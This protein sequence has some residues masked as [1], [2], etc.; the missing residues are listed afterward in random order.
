MTCIDIPVVITRTEY[1]RLLEL[2][3]SMEALTQRLQVAEARVAVEPK[4]YS[5]FE[6]GM[7][8]QGTTEQRVKIRTKDG[9]MCIS[10][11]A[12]PQSYDRIRTACTT[13]DS[14][15]VAMTNPFAMPAIEHRTYAFCG[16]CRKTGLR[17]FEEI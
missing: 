11:K 8:A 12:Y 5:D 17:M 4:R 7:G 2:K 13:N 15:I 14:S 6:F 9:H 1:D 10:D 16:T 3:S